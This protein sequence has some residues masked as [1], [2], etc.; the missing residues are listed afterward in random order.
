MTPQHTNEKDAL[1]MCYMYGPFRGWVR[2]FQC[3]LRSHFSCSMFRPMAK[4]QSD[5]PNVP[6]TCKATR[7][8]GKIENELSNAYTRIHELRQQVATQE[9]NSERLKGFF[10]AKEAEVNKYKQKCF[11]LSDEIKALKAKT[12][13]FKAHLLENQQLHE[14]ITG[15][16]DTIE[17]TNHLKTILDGTT[18]QVEELLTAYGPSE[19]SMR[20]IATYCVLL[21][22]ELTS[23]K[24]EVRIIRKDVSDLNRQLALKDGEI[25]ERSR[26]LEAASAEITKFKEQCTKLANQLENLPDGCHMPCGSKRL[27]DGQSAESREHVR[28]KTKLDSS[29]D[30]TVVPS[31]PVL[32]QRMG[33]LADK[34]PVDGKKI[35]PLALLGYSKMKIVSGV[36]KPTPKTQGDVNDDQ[37]LEMVMSKSSSRNDRDSK[38]RTGYNGLGGHSNHIQNEKKTIW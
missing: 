28:K 7:D 24:S 14:T 29:L 17:K 23:A 15:L 31:P 19:N 5:L 8:S 20:Q 21:K 36:K 10:T 11:T 27:C 34:E 18:A 3:S 35:F 12:K 4:V 6:N 16:R 26:K 22:R 37:L 1:S 2:H 25:A 33:F 9:E 30:I 13:T 32:K 38:I